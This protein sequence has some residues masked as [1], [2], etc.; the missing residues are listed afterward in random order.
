MTKEPAVSA[1]KI[2]IFLINVIDSSFFEYLI[3]MEQKT[4]G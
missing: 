2:L 4:L 3:G 1:N